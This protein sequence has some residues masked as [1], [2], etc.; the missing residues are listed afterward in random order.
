M[1]TRARYLG[2][3]DVSG[4]GSSISGRSGSEANCKAEKYKYLGEQSAGS[5][6]GNCR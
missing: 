4:D 2:R 6:G 1:Q 3:D 5:T